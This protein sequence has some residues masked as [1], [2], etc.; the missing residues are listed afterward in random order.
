M[1]GKEGVLKVQAC[2]RLQGQDWK[3]GWEG[4]RRGQARE[5]KDVGK[6][7]KSFEDVWGAVRK[8]CEIASHPQTSRRHWSPK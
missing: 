4:D 3:V 7:G 2:S 1:E 8:S 6:G 5:G